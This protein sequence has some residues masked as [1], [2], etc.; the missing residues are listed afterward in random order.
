MSYLYMREHAK[1]MTK[2]ELWRNKQSQSASICES[3]RSWDKPYRSHSK[4]NSSYNACDA[5]SQKKHH[6]A[7]LWWKVGV[8]CVDISGSLQALMQHWVTQ[9]ELCE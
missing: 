8:S 3:Y 5:E 4:G 9:R 6:R 1:E 7:V 2:S